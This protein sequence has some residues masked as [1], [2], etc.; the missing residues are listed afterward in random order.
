MKNTAGKSGIIF[1]IERC[2]FHDGSGLRT[3]VFLK[4]C[5]LRCKWCANPEGLSFSQDIA[6]F[7]DKC[8]DC[9]RCIEVCPE[10]AISK[11]SES[12]I[13]IDRNR[14]S[15]CARCVD[16][17]PSSA[18]QIIGKEYTTG[19]VIKE[20]LKDEIFYRVSGGGITLSGGEPLAQ[21]DLSAEILKKS[22]ELGL[23]TAIETSGQADWKVFQKVLK[24]CDAVL[25]DFKQIDP[26]KHKELTGVDNNRILNNAIKIS[27]MGIPIIARLPIIPGFN[28]SKEDFTNL[29]NF[30]KKLKTVIRVDLLPYHRLG[31][32]KYNALDRDYPV[33]DIQPPTKQ[34]LEDLKEIAESYSF[35]TSIG[36]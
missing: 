9:G 20:V 7:Q 27:K 19:E 8:T 15:L 2:A 34:E 12:K 10:K 23:G 18:V 21:P 26:Q 35:I 28:D 13:K 33:E 30:L 36:G 29:L 32:S 4:G 6:F 11:S 14:C 22:R 1:N 24:Y 31:T 5:P 25:F 3:I 16:V 17:C